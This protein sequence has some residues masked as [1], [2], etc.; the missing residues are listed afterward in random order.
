V[1]A[2]VVKSMMVFRINTR[3]CHYG[4]IVWVIGLLQELVVS[5]FTLTTL[6]SQEHRIPLPRCHFPLT[7]THLLATLT[8]N[9]DVSDVGI[10]LLA[11][12]TGSRMKASMPKQ[13][14]PLAGKPI[15]HH[16]IDLFLEQIPFD[17]V[18]LVIDPL[19]QTEYQPMIDKYKGR[20]TFA[21]P[22][23]ERQ[24][25]VENGLN[26][27]MLVSA[28]QQTCRYVAI[29]DSARPLVTIPEVMNVIRDART[30]GA[31]VLGVPCKATIKESADGGQFVLRTIPRD[32]LYEVHTP[33]VIRIDLLQSGFEQVAKNNW[34]VT[35][36]VSIVEQMEQPVKLTRGEYTNLKIT[37]PEDMEVAE[38]ILRERR[39]VKKRGR[40]QRWRSTM[41][42]WLNSN[43]EYLS[44]RVMFWKKKELDYQI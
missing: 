34:Q 17:H 11:G 4:Q 2:L 1:G 39:L 29:H 21:N 10:V 26:Q 22:G 30:T 43:T 41:S 36:D 40:L 28:D 14:L 9:D 38:A 35:D 19:Y 44:K 32:R 7:R 24:G 8:T 25:S 3:L 37:T 18:V 42:E 31:A 16:S 5:S 23:K 27:L 13:F 15:L 12:G 33:Q 6:Q 20:L